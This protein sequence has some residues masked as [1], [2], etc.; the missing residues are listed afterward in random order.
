MEERK[1]KVDEGS[2]R[3]GGRKQNE[4]GGRKVEEGRREGRTQGK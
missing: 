3:K 1:M 4:G 2:W